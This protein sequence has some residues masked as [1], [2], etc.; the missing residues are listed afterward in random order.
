MCTQLAVANRAIDGETVFVIH[1]RPFDSDGDVAVHQIFLIEI[2][3]PHRL[4]GPGLVD[5]DWL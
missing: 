2:G 3:E 1:R 5:D 4:P